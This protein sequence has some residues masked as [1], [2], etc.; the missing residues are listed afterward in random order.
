MHT[1]GVYVIREDD[2]RI[3][4]FNQRVKDVYPD[5]RPGLVCHEIWP[6]VCSNC[7]LIYIGGKKRVQ[8]N[9]LAR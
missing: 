8:K 2:H 5:M 7:P 3:L 6:G 1:I 4:Y 9:N